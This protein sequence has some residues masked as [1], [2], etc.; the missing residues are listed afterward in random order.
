VAEAATTTMAGVQ[1]SKAATTEL[2][3]MS[4][5]LHALVARFQL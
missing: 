1:Q 3:H 5:A 4:N 2:T